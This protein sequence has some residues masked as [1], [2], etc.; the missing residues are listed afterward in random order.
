MLAQVYCYITSVFI[1]SILV[2]INLSTLESEGNAFKAVF[3]LLLREFSS[4]ILS[5]IL[6]TCV[7][8]CMFMWNEFT[9][10]YAQGETGQA[11]M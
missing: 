5:F 11:Q 7:N 1:K 3:T 8:V 4:S 9:Y 2:T 10:V 6:L